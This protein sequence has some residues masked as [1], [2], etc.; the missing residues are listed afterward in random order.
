M[1]VIEF[2]AMDV[3]LPKI[4]KPKNLYLQRQMSSLGAVGGQF[5]L[6]K[7]YTKTEEE[8]HSPYF[9]PSSAEGRNLP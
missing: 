1:K 8:P 4:I 9:C 7:Y 5:G 6:L 2:T 3:E